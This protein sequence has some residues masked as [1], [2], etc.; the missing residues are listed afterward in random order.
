MAV[1]VVSKVLCFLFNKFV[2]CP[3]IQL[4]NV[5]VSIY[6]EQELIEVKDLLWTDVYKLKLNNMLR[7]TAPQSGTMPSPAH[8][9]KT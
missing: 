1:I 9:L 6:N 5:L 2:K 4:K 3:K 8:R 7:S